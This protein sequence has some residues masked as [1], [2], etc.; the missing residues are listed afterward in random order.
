[1]VDVDVLLVAH[2]RANYLARSLPRLLDSLPSGARAWVWQNESHPETSKIIAHHKSHPRFYRFHHS[3]RNRY[4]AAP[5]NWLW[6]HSEGRLLGKVDDDCLVPDGWIQDLAAAH[7]HPRIG[8]I[9]AWHFLPEDLLPRTL[10]ERTAPIGGGRRIIRNCWVGGSGYLMKR[11]CVIENGFLSEER[12][13]TRF[14]LDASLQGWEIGWHYPLVLQDHMDDPRSPN[15]G[16]IS[17]EDLLAQMPL[18]A[19]KLVEPTLDNWIGQLKASAHEVQTASLR[20]KD[21]LGWRK[22]LRRFG[23]RIPSHRR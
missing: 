7:Q 14:C 9:A 3:A 4:L 12:S 8:I 13:F 16:I 5:T 6:T 1:M 17:D 20:P 2:A 18:G 11:A 23:T 19:R 22:R 10:D 21:H 15:T